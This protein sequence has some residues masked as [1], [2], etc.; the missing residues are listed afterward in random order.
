MFPDVTQGQKLSISCSIFVHLV[1]CLAG[2]T[3]FDILQGVA[4]F[5][6]FS[7]IYYYD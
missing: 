5:K 3:T 6:Y 7:D 2:F 1:L 4:F